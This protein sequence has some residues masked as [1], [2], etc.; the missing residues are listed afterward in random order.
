MLKSGGD[1]RKVKVRRIR[2]SIRGGAYENNLKL[3]V[4]ME[5]MLRD[6]EL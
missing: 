6:L 3:E 2:A 4:A 1:L 5:R